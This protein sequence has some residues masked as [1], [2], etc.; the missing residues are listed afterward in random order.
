[1]ERAEPMLRVATP[2]DASRVEALMKESAAVLF[3]R[4]YD[5]RQSAS[6]VRYVAQIERDAA[7]AG[8]SSRSA[9]PLLDARA[10]GSS[11]CWP[12]F[13]VCRCTSHAASSRSRRLSSRPTSGVL[14]APSKGSIASSIET[15]AIL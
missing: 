3:P 4:Y 12:P 7:S 8:A 1:M 9:R 5:E 13:P 14:L 2:D 10:I 6:T 15:P 11:P